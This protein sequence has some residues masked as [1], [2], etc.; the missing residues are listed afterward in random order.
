MAKLSSVSLS[1]LVN[2]ALQIYAETGVQFQAF[3]EICL[4]IAVFIFVVEVFLKVL[5]IPYSLAIAHSGL[6]FLIEHC[7]HQTKE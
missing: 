2:K 5:F 3:I 4:L 6:F 7:S 1:G